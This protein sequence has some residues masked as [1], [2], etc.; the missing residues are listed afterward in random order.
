MR[1]FMDFGDKGRI[2]EMRRL[3]ERVCANDGDNETFRAIFCE[4]Q[5]LSDERSD[6]V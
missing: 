2:A 5:R 4:I 3:E 1:K 6:F